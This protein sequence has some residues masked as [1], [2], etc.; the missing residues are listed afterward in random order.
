MVSSRLTKE[1]EKGGG[2]RVKGVIY[3][4]EEAL[5]STGHRV[6]LATPLHATD[7]ACTNSPPPLL[8]LVGDGGTQ[9]G[10]EGREISLRARV[11]GS[12]ENREPTWP[13]QKRNRARDR[14]GPNLTLAF[15]LNIGN[16]N[17]Y[18]A[19]IRT[20]HLDVRR[21]FF[22][23]RILRLVSRSGSKLERL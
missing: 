14:S 15:F 22:L 10:G 13:R 3:R 16:I 12:R 11:H 21:S 2:R 4:G 1:E 7:L 18:T 5:G 20:L 17:I 23:S 19:K 6:H 9:K 8:V